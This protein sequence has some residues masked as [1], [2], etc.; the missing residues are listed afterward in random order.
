MYKFVVE[1]HGS[2]DLYEELKAQAEAGKGKKF[3][4][5]TELE[6]LQEIDRDKN[7]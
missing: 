4:W 1:K 5:P 7:E 3:D 6:R 2:I